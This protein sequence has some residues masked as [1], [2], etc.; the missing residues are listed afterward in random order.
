MI[1]PS[2]KM[3][4]LVVNL[5]AL[6]VCEAAPTI[7]VTQLIGSEWGYKFSYKVL[8]P[9]E[10]GRTV[11]CNNLTTQC[12]VRA[13]ALNR[14]ELSNARCR[15]I[16]WDT[17]TIE[18]Q[19]TIS[20]AKNIWRN[21]YGAITRTMDY[22]GAGMPASYLERCFV[23]VVMD[24]A[25][26]WPT[27]GSVFPGST[28]AFLPPANVTC[29]A[30]D[31]LNINYGTL[32]DYD[33]NSRRASGEINITCT[34]PSTVKF[35]LIGSKKIELGNSGTLR[36]KLVTD[37]EKDLADGFSLKVGTS[38]TTLRITSVLESYYNYFTPGYFS[39]NG[40]LMM[41]YQ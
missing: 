27:T 29:T 24:S 5:I 2:I 33:L 19:A 32:P 35:Q 28:C 21:R 34:S 17:I 18:P 4:A 14:K 38:N 12:T 30:S 7:E 36:A 16:I 25:D 40:V 22:S 15:N 6:S 13:C 1:K 20:D 31:T 3:I 11:I 10:E 23:M 26:E 9:N 37:T 8:W 41:T 39:G